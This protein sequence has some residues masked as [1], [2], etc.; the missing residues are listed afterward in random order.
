MAMVVFCHM[1]LVA[2][3]RYHKPKPNP[4][5]VSRSFIGKNKR[6]MIAIQGHRM[7]KA[8]QIQYVV[9]HCLD[10]STSFFGY[11]VKC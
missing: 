7:Q 4:I 5:M 3:S 8:K 11:Q 2:L 1:G 9:I 6:G 10:N